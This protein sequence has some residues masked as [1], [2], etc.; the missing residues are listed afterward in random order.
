MTPHPIGNLLRY[1]QRYRVLFW[2]SVTSSVCNKV[3][4][5]MPPLLV[6]WVIDSVRGEPPLGSLRFYPQG[7]SLQ[8]WQR[9]SPGL[10]WSFWF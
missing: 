7:L 4:D 10:V 8:L 9:F 5:L 1:V 3:L 6:G 2:L